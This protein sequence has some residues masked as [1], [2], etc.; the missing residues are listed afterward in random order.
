MVPHLT[1]ALTGPL[2]ELERRFLAASPQIE[3]WLR[4]PWQTSLPSTT[5]QESLF[6]VA[7]QPS[8]DLPSNKLTQPSSADTSWPAARNKPNTAEVNA[9]FFTACKLQEETRSRGANPAG[10]VPVGSV[11]H[12]PSQTNLT[13]APAPIKVPGM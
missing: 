11:I 7:F 3:H 1:T 9:V 2:L 12:R 4:G 8:S 13:S 6:S 10:T 5:F